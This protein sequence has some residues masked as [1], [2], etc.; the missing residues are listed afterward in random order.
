MPLLSV[1]SLS[2]EVD[3]RRLLSNVSFDLSSGD[4]VLL[5]GSNG[6]GKTSLL[7]CIA[8]LEDAWQS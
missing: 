6:A 5:A 8:F 2:F 1:N 3:G 4:F 7:K